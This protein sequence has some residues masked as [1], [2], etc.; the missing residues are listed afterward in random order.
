MR[1]L[2]QELRE[3]GFEGGGPDQLNPKNRERFA[4]ELQKILGE[5]KK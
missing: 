4:N 2:M 1:N 5:C 3:G